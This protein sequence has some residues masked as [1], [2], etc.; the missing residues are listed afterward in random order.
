MV[1]VAGTCA[2]L[3]ENASGEWW[4]RRADVKRVFRFGT[5]WATRPEAVEELRALL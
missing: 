1:K 4:E 5:C 2:R 3:R